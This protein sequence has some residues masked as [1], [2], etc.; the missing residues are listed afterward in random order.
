MPHPNEVSVSKG[1]TPNSTGLV[2][3]IELAQ[4][5]SSLN[6]KA[7][8]PDASGTS[9][10]RALAEH[11]LT[12]KEWRYGLVIQELHRW[13]AIFQQEFRLDLPEVAFCIG[14]TRLRC[15]G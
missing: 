8:H 14:Y 1:S 6:H 2:P 12:D 3:A 9:V 10:Y 7:L 11:Q 15:F 5:V 4:G 13:R